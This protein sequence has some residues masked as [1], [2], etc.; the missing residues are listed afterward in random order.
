MQDFAVGFV[1]AKNSQ[2]NGVEHRQRLVTGI[3]RELGFYLIWCGS[4]FY[5]GRDPELIADEQWRGVAAAWK[6]SFPNDAAGLTPGFRQTFGGADALPA[7][8]TPLGPV[9][10]GDLA[11]GKQ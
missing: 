7:L 9:F 2:A 11:N 1:H 8:T 3:S 5:G 4:F 10:C 6:L